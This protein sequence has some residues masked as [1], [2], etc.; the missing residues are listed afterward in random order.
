MKKLLL[1]IALIFPAPAFAQQEEAKDSISNTLDELVVIADTQ[2]ETSKKVILRPTGLDKKH[3]TNGYSLLENMNLPDFNVNASAKTISTIAGRDVIILINGVEAT[4]DELGTLA[5]S[6]IV[7]I[8]YQRNPGGRYVG[9]G[10]VINFITVHYNYGGNLYLSAGE[11]LA[12]QHGNYIGMVNYKKNSLTLTLTANGKWEHFSQLN[13]ADNLAMLSDGELHQSITPIEGTTRTD[14]QYLNFKLAHATDN[15]S[16]DISFAFTRSATPENI[17]KDNISY[18]GMYNFNSTSE[19][20]SNERG[21]SP[22]LKMHY[23]LYLPGSHSIMINANI[24]HGHT[25][26]RSNYTE[27]DV[28]E[29]WSNTKEN[30]VLASVTLGYFK[31][32]ASGLSLGTTVDEYYN[33]YHDVYSGS[34]SGKQTLKNNHTMA[35]LHIDQTLPFGLSYYLSAGITNL[36]SVIG[37]HRDNQFSPMA[38][39]GLTWAIN[40]KH[41]VS[42]TGNYAHSIYNPSY[43]ND[44][45]L[46]TS[47]FEATMGNPDL[48]QLN[49]LGNIISYNGRVG[50]L[51][52]SFTY[53]FLKYFNNTSNRY[54]AESNIMYHQL[55]NDGSFCYNKLIFGLSANLL[56]SKLRLKGN[57]IFSINKFDSDYR[58]MN[59]NDWRADFTVSY[60]FGN[61][62]VGGSYT[63]PYNLLSVEGT[64][65]HNPGQYGL[66]VN[67]QKGSWAAE[68]SVENFLNRRM[69]IRTIS[70]Y[71]VYRSN[72]ELRS[73]LKGRNVSIGV[74]YILSY[75]KKTE[76]ARIETESKVNSAILRPF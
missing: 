50:H 58:P 9:S 59:S 60:M 29:I 32:F 22:V 75:G 69:N 36:S 70:D 49:A 61:W 7:K 47:F 15:H 55:V 38:F 5:A 44:A 34:F 3:S 26:F 2:A 10:A 16:F 18:M 56:D 53:D 54:F 24:R 37:A 67:W 41:S 57:A 1:I 25:D 14:S 43:K 8:E 33:Y 39:Y 63:L 31:A 4:P 72:S 76:R 11:G 66:F 52:F 45:V 42:L 28:E 46:R 74:T 62:Q 68:F 35:M 13:K 6:E 30:S 19:R 27:T 40:K 48:K 71:G 21:F 17:L 12:R 23:N 51:G 73:D 65:I 20:K 64:K